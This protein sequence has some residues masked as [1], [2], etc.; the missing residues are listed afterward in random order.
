ME[1]LYLS[2]YKCLKSLPISKEVFVITY[3]TK[4]IEKIEDLIKCNIDI[5]GEKE[6]V[7]QEL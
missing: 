3:V 5:S 2:I 7:S 6:F 1:S 4:D